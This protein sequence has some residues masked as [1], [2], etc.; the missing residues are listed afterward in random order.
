MAARRAAKQTDGYT[1]PSLRRK[2]MLCL[3]SSTEKK[4]Y[5]RA[6]KGQAMDRFFEGE[7]SPIKQIDPC[8]INGNKGLSYVFGF[9]HLG[10][11]PY[12]IC[13]SSVLFSAQHPNRLSALSGRIYFI[14]RSRRTVRHTS[15]T[16]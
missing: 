3:R 11:L 15:E 1:G 6:G 4:R 2:P 14:I 10:N 13:I 16:H 9:V 8:F 7:R 5:Y 12:W